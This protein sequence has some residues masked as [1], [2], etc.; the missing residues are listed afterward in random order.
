MLE[1]E[2]ELD[3]PEIDETPIENELELDETEMEELDLDESKFEN[4]LV[5]IES[6]IEQAPMEDEPVIEEP[7]LEEFVCP[8]CGSN[9]SA[10]AS[11]CSGCGEPFSPI[12]NG[13]PTEYYEETVA[14]EE[15]QYEVPQEEEFCP[16][17]DTQLDADGSCIQ[18]SPEIQSDE[19]TDGC[20]ICGSK[21]FSVESGDLVSCGD[22]GNVYIRKEY[23]GIEQSWKW[24]FWVG[25]VFIIIGDIGVAL[26]S[27]VHNV[28]GWSPLGNLY[29]GYG[30]IDQM[31]GI[32]GIVLFTIGLLLFAWS[33]KREREVQCPS[34][35]V[36]VLE[37]QL[38]EFEEEEI[39]EIPEEMAVESVLEEIGEAVECPSCGSEV[40][41]FDTACGNCGVLFEVEE[42]FD[43]D[44]DEELDEEVPALEPVETIEEPGELLSASE[45]DED[46]MVMESLELEGPEES[47]P[48]N[49]ESLEALSELE[50][51]IEAPLED[52]L[53]VNTC[54]SCGAMVG[55]GLDT[56]PGCGSAIADEGGE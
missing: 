44:F 34:C 35:K 41:M 25:L 9:V 10:D 22:C 16:D 30:W 19:A 39:E 45:I 33:F 49:G 38:T 46:Q 29:L 26:G 3:E 18:C 37:D 36:L 50:S 56:C 4:T 54:P 55:K 32:L 51:A 47:V 24:K 11:E 5:D 40:S 23:A 43:Q 52:D 17:C 42:E 27:Y 28:I 13:E 12:E 20:P 21:M 31:V 2:P 15:G 14:D 1:D 6:E 48:L 7:E 8:M 53:E